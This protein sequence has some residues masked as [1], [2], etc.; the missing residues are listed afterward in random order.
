MAKLERAWRRDAR[1]APACCL[2][3]CGR[4]FSG[5]ASRLTSAR[6]SRRTGQV[7]GTGLSAATRAL[8]AARS[9]P[10]EMID[11]RRLH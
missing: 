8:V 3:H 5:A 2:Q 4:A 10:S 11:H 9:G 7:D 6:A 1:L